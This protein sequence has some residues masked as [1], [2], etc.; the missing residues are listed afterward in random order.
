[1]YE[2]RDVSILLL[3]DSVYESSLWSLWI[4]L[5]WASTKGKL[6]LL[7]YSF[8]AY[9]LVSFLF[10]LVLVFAHFQLI[11]LSFLLIFR[12]FFILLDI[13][14]SW[15]KCVTNIISYLCLAFSPFEFVIN[16]LNKLRLKKAHIYKRFRTCMFIIYNSQKDGNKPNVHQLINR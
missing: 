16:A 12:N 10:G 14:P 4:K 3:M 9:H 15:D 8:F 5:L 13:S 6:M 7:E 11:K 1:M 2:S